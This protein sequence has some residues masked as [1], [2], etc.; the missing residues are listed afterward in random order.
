MCNVE[1]HVNFS[2]RKTKKKNSLLS[3]EWFFWK[4]QYNHN[5]VC[6]VFFFSPSLDYLM[7]VPSLLLFFFLLLFYCFPLRRCFQ[8]NW[9]I[10]RT[11][12]FMIWHE[13]LNSRVIRFVCIPIHRYGHCPSHRTY[14]M[15]IMLGHGWS[16]FVHVYVCFCWHLYVYW[17]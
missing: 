2:T 12:T 3:M 16:L 9:Q 10:L 6:E 11:H 5:L 7:V 1:F 13:M 15:Y 4:Y 14:V 17:S 8:W